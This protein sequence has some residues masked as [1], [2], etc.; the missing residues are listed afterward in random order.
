MTKNEI[1]PRLEQAFQ[2][3]KPRNDIILMFVATTAIAVIG[4][5]IYGYLFG[6]TPSAWIAFGVLVAI[7]NMSI[8]TGYHRL[9]SHKTYEAHW[10]MRLLLMLVGALALQN[11]ILKWASDHRRHHGHVD[12]I[13]KDPYSANRGFWF[14]HIGWML[15][16]YPSAP[17]DF[18]NV[19]DLEK[20]PIVKWQHKYYLPLT[21]SLNLG[22]PIALGVIFGNVVEMLLIAGFLRV[23]TSHHT[24]FFINS[25][26]HIIGNQP[27][28]TQNT[29]RDN[30]IL[31]VLTFGEGYHNFHHAHPADYRN[32]IRAWQWDPTKW[33][34]RFF[35]ILGLARNLKTTQKNNVQ[36]QH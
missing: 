8:T 31:A 30:F 2:A 15:K 35:W 4:V 24:T 17:M 36:N 5:P 34:I 6:Y 14:S 23:V 3:A 22:V 32:A 26:A 27:Y 7:C 18:S 9:W 16:D 13:Y 33:L 28:S 19:R 12:D 21:V 20:D 1:N 11:S 10:S 25:L 29:A